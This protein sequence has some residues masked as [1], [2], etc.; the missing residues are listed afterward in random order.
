MHV[1]FFTKC[2]KELP[3][4][5]YGKTTFDNIYHILNMVKPLLTF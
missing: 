1:V 3:V 4:K 2:K 5:C